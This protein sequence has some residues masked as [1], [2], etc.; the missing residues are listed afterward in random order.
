M[1][2]DHTPR[3]PRL[4]DRLLGWFCAPHLLE[5][6]QGD[7]HEEFGY[8]VQRVGLPKARL[9]YWRDVLGF[10][11]PFA[12]RRKNGSYPS[13]A[14]LIAAMLNNYFKIAWRSLRK[15][16]PYTLTNITGL[17]VGLTAAILLLLWVRDELSY[18][19]FHR[20]APDIYR[21]VAN[22]GTDGVAKHF[23]TTP[24]AVA[25]AALNNLAQVKA[26]TRITHYWDVSLFS[27]GNKT[28]RENNCALVDASFFTLFDFPLVSGNPGK[29]FAGNRSVVITQSMAR[30]YFGDE[31]ALGKLIRV[32][33]KDN[34]L[35]S[36]VAADLPP[37]SD[38]QYDFFFPFSII[39]EFYGNPAEAAN[40]YDGD[41]NNYDYDTY[42][43]LD[44]RAA[45]QT[46]AAKLTALHKQNRSDEM[47]K[48]LRYSLQ[49]L[50]Q[51]HLYK[52][53]GTEGTM[54]TVRILML[55]GIAILVIACF[56]YVN[57]VTARA[58]GRA[59]E[60]GVRKI[61]GAS[62]AQ[63]FGQFLCESALLFVLAFLVSIGL[64]FLLL[65]VYNQIA[66]KAQ[67][68]HV[69]DP[70]LIG[71]LGALL[72]GMLLV[73]GIYPALLLSSFRP[74]PAIKGGG[75]PGGS[76]GTLRKILVSSQFVVSM[77]LITGTIV[78]GR[79]LSYIQAKN[80]GYDK[81]NVFRFD[82]RDM[83]GHYQSV[84]DELLR[85]P[86]VRAVTGVWSG[87]LMELWSNTT[88]NDWDGKPAGITFLITQLAVERDFL[89]T[90]GLKLV[91]GK[92]FT[93]TPADS[94]HFLLNETAIREMGIKDP[95]GKRFKLQDREGIIAG[96]V[97]DFHFKKMQQKIEPCIL[98]WGP[99]SIKQ[100]C[101]R[102]T[103]HGAPKAIAAAEKIWKQYNPAYPFEY[104]F[105]DH[106]FDRL[107]QN[108]Q[109]IGQIF[110]VL[111]GVAVF[112]SCLGL[113][114]LATFVALTRKKE[115]GIR[116][117]LGAS[118]LGIVAML[119]RDFLKLV[120]LAFL[121]SVL[122][123]WYGMRWWLEDYAYRTPVGWS[124]FALTGSL[125]VGIAL[126]TVSFQ[127]VKAAL[128]NPVN[129]LRD[130]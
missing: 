76:A 61:I 51:L 36:G 92:G 18:D 118:V 47:T 29:P 100:M 127:S 67:R 113:F 121:V 94:S 40:G 57:L 33:A 55:T 23:S 26:A 80:I 107:Y 89:P 2:P 58:A 111:A 22:F 27:T 7:L 81:E 125:A 124:V 71:L 88:Q 82:M 8:Q 103:A 48:T 60:V 63:L 35:V 99:Q 109:R 123:A 117:V 84:R 13:P 41:W 97:S 112:I 128:A 69:F 126:L 91:Q 9:R 30:K 73:A 70:D 78:I 96:V 68:F 110:R 21:A 106:E 98:F 66:G 46:I 102:T 1:T 44:A 79:Q 14:L 59:G 130:E 5:E 42:L 38:I 83:R 17:A 129:N 75:I 77:V 28:F 74:L 24:P 87:N 20:N 56:N 116:K 11:R 15:D 93:G 104:S 6:V 108:E 72:A 95:V 10:V 120:G 3:P 53:D 4:A 45:P 43:Q 90:M 25:T 119:S 65:P 31:N 64:V 16:K 62:K 39:N 85:E 54:Q 12:P 49:P 122:I 19:T 32:D 105:L 115:I 86:D 52:P 114:G 34:Y 50:S 37:N 101:V